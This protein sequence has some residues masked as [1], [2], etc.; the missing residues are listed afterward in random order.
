MMFFPYFLDPFSK[1]GFFSGFV[2]E[3][4]DISISQVHEMVGKVLKENF[5][6]PLWSSLKSLLP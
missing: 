1:P 6:F 5:R 3:G 4:P 2:T